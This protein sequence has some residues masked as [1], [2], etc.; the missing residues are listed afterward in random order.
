METQEE[1]IPVPV[2][3][4]ENFFECVTFWDNVLKKGP[5]RVVTGEDGKN[6]AEYYDDMTDEDTSLNG[7]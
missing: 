1:I 5:V 6:Y 3:T 2:L 4:A 7:G